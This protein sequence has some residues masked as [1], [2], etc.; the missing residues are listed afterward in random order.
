MSEGIYV[1]SRNG[2]YQGK[3]FF[4]RV[5]LK[6]CDPA[7]LLILAPWDSHWTSNLQNL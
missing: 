7:G 2:K 4:P 1:V 6:E 5:S 3:E